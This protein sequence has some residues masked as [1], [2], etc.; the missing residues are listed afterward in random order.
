MLT[1]AVLWIL[2]AVGRKTYAAAGDIAQCDLWFRRGRS[3]VGS[4]RTRTPI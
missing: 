1:A 2:G 4:D 3:R